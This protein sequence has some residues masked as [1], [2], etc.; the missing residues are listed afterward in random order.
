MRNTQY[1]ATRVPPEAAR[2]LTVLARRN[3]RSVSAELR[4]ALVYYLETATTNDSR[5]PRQAAAIENPPAQ[6]AGARAG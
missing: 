6:V 2:Q 4:R 3:D 5:P 1:I